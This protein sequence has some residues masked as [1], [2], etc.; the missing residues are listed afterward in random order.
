MAA[1]FGPGVIMQFPE[2]GVLE[3]LEQR[4]FANGILLGGT[5]SDYYNVIDRDYNM[6]SGYS[7]KSKTHLKMRHF[8]LFIVNAQLYQI[9][10]WKG[11]EQKDLSTVD[12]LHLNAQGDKGNA[13]LLVINPVI[14]IN[15]GKTWRLV[16]SASR[17]MRRTHY[18]YYD[19]VRANTF[20]FRVGLTKH[21]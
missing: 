7:I 2:V 17:Y 8:G 11:Y 4:L 9:F 3:G 19:D 13:L 12:P 21:L 1:A 10:T 16:A 5:K 14:E 15:M 18:K 20:E 6:G